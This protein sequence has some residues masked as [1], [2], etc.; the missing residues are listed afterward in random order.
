MN[1]ENECIC[2]KSNG[3]KP[4]YPSICGKCGGWF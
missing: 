4:M 1:V 2:G 3:K